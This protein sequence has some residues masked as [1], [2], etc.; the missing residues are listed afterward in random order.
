MSPVVSF[1]RVPAQRA[2]WSLAA[3]LVVACGS[4]GGDE[5]TSNACVTPQ[6]LTAGGSGPSTSGDPD[7]TGTSGDGGSDSDTGPLMCSG[8]G[9]D[10]VC[11]QG[12]CMDIPDMCPCPLETY[13]NL[14]MN[15]CV[16]G[17]T[18][19]A[20]CDKGRIC[21]DVKRECFDGCRE[22]ADCEGAGE[23]CDAMTCRL[24]CY[25]DADCPLEQ[26]CDEGAKSCYDGCESLANC[27]PGKICKAGTC[28]VGC[29]DS[30]WCGVGEICKNDQ[31]VV[32]CATSDECGAGKACLDNKCVDGCKESAECPVGQ[33]CADT[34]CVAGCGA[35]GG[36]K[37][38]ADDL[39]CPIGK[40][41]FATGCDGGGNNCAKFDCSDACDDSCHATANEP[42]V[43][44][45]N[46]AD[47]VAYCMLECNSDFDCSAG[48]V[49]APHAYPADNPNNEIMLCRDPCSTNAQCANMYFMGFPLNCTCYQGLCVNLFMNFPLYCQYA[50]PES[51]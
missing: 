48:Q 47:T 3:A 36:S 6:C 24:G 37:A 31:C 46:A 7:P 1:L 34:K 10:Q 44:Y 27:G 28:Q 2:L 45:A 32:G 9:A 11:V 21:D 8:C 25:A 13:C 4:P 15:K 50:T 51:D 18:K 20:E 43:C 30:S 26:L 39:R 12:V 35:P 33:Y 29:L 42:Y 38:D 40:A 17:C 23:I 14:S 5:G 16:V 19:D 41:C 22:D 49:C